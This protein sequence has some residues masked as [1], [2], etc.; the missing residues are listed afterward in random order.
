MLRNQRLELANE[1]SSG[2]EG[3]LGVD[4]IFECGRAQFLEAPELSLRKRFELQVG[5]GW[6][7]PKRERFS[8]LLDAAPR[9][10][11]PARRQLGVRSGRG[12]PA[13]PA[14]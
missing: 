9:P 8:E 4:Q 5:E 2:G 3:E 7:A 1:L 11:L 13:R 6:P 14:H 12:R 10:R